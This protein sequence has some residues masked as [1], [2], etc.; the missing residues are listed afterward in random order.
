MLMVQS[1]WDHESQLDYF[2]VALSYRSLETQ[3]LALTVSYVMTDGNSIAM[4][5]NP[6]ASTWVTHVFSLSHFISVSISLPS[7]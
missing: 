4:P 1:I 7:P 6:W 3:R 2:Q 5:L